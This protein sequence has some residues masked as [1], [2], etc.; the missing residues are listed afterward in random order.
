MSGECT[1]ILCVESDAQ[2]AVTVQQGLASTGREVTV[3]RSCEEAR[4]TV[5]SFA[6]GVFAIEVAD[7]CGVELAAEL[8]Q[9]QRVR[10]AVFFTAAAYQP[11]LRRAAQLGA[12]V[13]HDLGLAALRDAVRGLAEYD[14]GTRTGVYRALCQ[15]MGDDLAQRRSA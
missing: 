7:G 13:G 10:R 9:Q 3:A 2:R 6:V 4:N 15:M 12:V 11:V 8:L 5:G 1:S 14:E